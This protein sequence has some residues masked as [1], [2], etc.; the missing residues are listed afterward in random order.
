MSKEIV[1]KQFGANA[2]AYVT[3][4]VH[5]KGDSLKRLVERVK[6]EKHW[7]ALDVATA[8]GHTALAFAH[9][10]EHVVA[11]DL[12]DEMLEQARKLAGE[13]GATNVVVTKA[14]AEDLPFADG[15]FDLVTCRIAPHHFPDVPKFISEVWRVLKPGG[16][17]GLVDNIAPDSVLTPGFSDAEIAAAARMYNE[18]EKIRDPSHGR[19]LTV[20]EWQQIVSK[21]GFAIESS[22]LLDK[23]MDFSAW[24]H[25]MQVAAATMQILRGMLDTASP[26]LRAFIRP[27]KS[28]AM[29]GFVLT[30]LVLVSKKPI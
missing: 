8:A 26:A 1:Q 11:S 5:A 22:E 27:N 14:D 3:S 24:C 25:N 9:H 10:V 7:H 29:G 6:P 2:A 23:A 16:A 13:R 20:S 19:A 4:T 21:Q 17:F 28:G 12:T 18:F 15:S 30:E